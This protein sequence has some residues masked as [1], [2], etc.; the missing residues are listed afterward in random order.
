M[1]NSKKGIG[2][3]VGLAGVMLRPTDFRR[4]S[5]T[6]ELGPESESESGKREK[7]E[8]GKVKG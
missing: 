8:K 5:T 3:D 7:R 2:G 6:A 4:V 1:W